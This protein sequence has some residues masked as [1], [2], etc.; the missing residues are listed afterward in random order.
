MVLHELADNAVNI[1]VGS[2]KISATQAVKQACAGKG[3]NDEQLS[4]VAGMANRAILRHTKSSAD[5][6]VPERFD[7]AK[8]DQIVDMATEQSP[9][10]TT[11]DV[12]KEHLED[13]ERLA[14]THQGAVETGGDPR[15]PIRDSVTGKGNSLSTASGP[16]SLDEVR[17]MIRR[18]DRPFMS[19]TGGAFEQKVSANIN[20]LRA[21]AGIEYQAPARVKLS[22]ADHTDRVSDLT[23]EAH[24][25]RR[26]LGGRLALAE[27]ELAGETAELARGIAHAE[28]SSGF[29]LGELLHATHCGMAA[30]EEASCDA[31]FKHSFPV[32]VQAARLDVDAAAGVAYDDQGQLKQSSVDDA[33]ARMVRR[34]R[35]TAAAVDLDSPLCKQAGTVASAYE[36]W[37]TLAQVDEQLASTARKGHEFLGDLGAPA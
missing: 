28:K 31:A 5:G 11:D 4:R 14:L 30:A 13:T 21:A 19:D 25:A 37:A 3:L 20:G 6:I 29:T 34:A 18:D 9:S 27:A 32:I 22:E 10:T 36:K 16:A 33:R 7:T 35:V 17:S 8:A 1:Y 15:P 12:R 26:V 23:F 2:E 24:E